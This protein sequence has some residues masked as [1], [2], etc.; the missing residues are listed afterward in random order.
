MPVLDSMSLHS[1]RTSLGAIRVGNVTRFQVWAPDARRVEVEF[2]DGDCKSLPLTRKA[3]G[4]FSGET[5]AAVTLYKYRVDDS[6]PWP[7]PCSRFQP[8]GVHGPSLIV[9]P[10]AFDWT[11]ATWRGVTIE[12]QVIYELHIGAFTPEGTFDAA[13]SKLE[14]LRDLGVTVLEIMPV[15]QCPGRWNWGYDGVYLFAPNHMYGDYEAFKRFVD[16][17][18]ALGLAVILDVVYNHLGPDG[19]YL[20]CYSSHYFSSRYHT[21]WGKPF[22]VDGEHSQGVRDFIVG[23]ACHWIRE[24]HL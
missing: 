17:A 19:N 5:T 8:H 9:A 3:G 21:D 7:D 2:Q 20:P 24:F 14:H 13:A 6:G 11:D 15:A 18:H 22:N 16:R 12:R 10:D 1:D 4:Y 23:N